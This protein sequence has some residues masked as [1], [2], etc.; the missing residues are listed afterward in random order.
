MQLQT[1]DDV[2]HTSPFRPFRLR[3]AGGKSI[4]VLHPEIAVLSP[5]DNVIFLVREQGRFYI[6]DPESVTSLETA[7]TP[8]ELEQLLKEAQSSF[9]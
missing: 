6:L 7:S 2:L 4:A 3:T 9:N 5:K 1:I 8:A